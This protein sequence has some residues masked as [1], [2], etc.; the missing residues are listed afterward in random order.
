MKVKYINLKKVNAEIFKRK[1][2]FK[3]WSNLNSYILGSHV[4]QFEKKYAN[5]SGTKYCISVASGYDAIYLTLLAWG[6][7]KGDE[8]IVPAQTF[9]STL[10]AI[11]N[12]GATPVGCDIDANTLNIDHKKIQKL[13][14]K[15]TKAIIP[16]HLCGRIANLYEIKKVVAKYKIKILEDNAQ[17]QGAKLQGCIAGGI[18]DAG[19]TSFYPTKNLGCLGDGGAITTNSKATAERVTLL[20]NYGSVAK[21]HYKGIGINSRLDEV[22]AVFLMEKL[23]FLK[24][25]NKKRQKIAQTYNENIKNKS[26]ILPSF[27]K[28]DEH[29]WHIYSIRTKHRDALQSYLKKQGVETVIHYPI[30]PAFSG[31]FSKRSNVKFIQTKKHCAETLS[32]PCYPNM[33]IQHLEYVIKQLNKF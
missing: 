19:A 28:N 33:P 22:Q 20:R 2:I 7:K 6:I 10:L 1:E 8:V 21:Y 4:K 18:G 3:T 30:P 24:L 16:V 14:T 5:F 17:A 9:I 11:K 27:S 12:V 31:I 25:Q 23:K 13:I 29:V 15:K 26:I 32:L